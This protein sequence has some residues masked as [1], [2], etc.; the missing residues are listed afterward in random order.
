MYSGMTVRS[1]RSGQER[2]FSLIE[3]LVVVVILTVVFGIVVD[4]ITQLQRRNSAETAKL[5]I[6]Q[7][8][9]EFLDQLVRDLHQA[10]YPSARMF[11]AAPPAN[12]V[13]AG[14]TTFANN[15]IVYEADTD[16]NGNVEQITV[17]VVGADGVVGDA[18]PCTLQRASVNKGTAGALVFFTAV[19]N[20]TNN[21]PFSAFQ[22]D[23]TA[24]V[25]PVAGANLPLIKTVKILVNVQSPNAD[26]QNKSLPAISMNAEATISNQ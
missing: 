25:M 17:Q 6:N 22:S 1:K 19:N 5:D 26:L 24:L 18:C 12:S 16:G 9:R 4:G 8:G 15:Q 3:L 7:E 21:T 13:A 20:V 2:G 11:N 14:I 10:G 23:G